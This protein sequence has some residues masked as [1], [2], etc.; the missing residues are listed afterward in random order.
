VLS[1]RYGK[2]LQNII[3][4]FQRSLLMQIFTQ[5]LKL[6]DLIP[7]VQ[8]HQSSSQCGASYLRMR[9]DS[10]KSSQN[11][12]QQRVI[13]SPAL[14]R[15]NTTSVKAKFKQGLLQGLIIHLSRLNST[16]SYQQRQR[17]E[18]HMFLYRAELDANQETGLLGYCQFIL[19]AR[20]HSPATVKINRE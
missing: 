2:Y 3:H 18:A 1:K 19:H 13:Y 15:S 14:I 11:R 16:L 8:Y 12:S 4:R 9:A 5:L 20:F 10:T 17:C 7:S 6:T